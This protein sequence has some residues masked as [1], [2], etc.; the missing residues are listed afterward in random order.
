V[1]LMR[2]IR[3]CPFPNAHS[4]N[5]DHEKDAD[6]G[7]VSVGSTIADCGSLAE[8]CTQPDSSLDDAAITR[9]V[10]HIFIR[11]RGVLCGRLLKLLPADANCE[12]DVEAPTKAE[13][14]GVILPLMVDLIHDLGLGS[15]V[16]TKMIEHARAVIGVEVSKMIALAISSKP[17]VKIS[18]PPR[19]KAKSKRR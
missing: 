4:C 14:A 13:L 8:V 10:D 15:A 12:D 19:L 11:Y 1:K 2:L 18:R 16:E 6:S 17:P 9:I 7:N 5:T 3:N